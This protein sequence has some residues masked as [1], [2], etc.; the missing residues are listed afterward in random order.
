MTLH[1]Y[2][3]MHSEMTSN[4]ATPALI[5]THKIPTRLIWDFDFLW[6]TVSEFY[7]T[8]FSWQLMEDDLVI[9]VN[10]GTPVFLKEK[11]QEK[12]AILPYD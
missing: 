6:K 12:G 1:V 8:E 9:T 5:F 10:I 4:A 7:G 3:T 11:L 2:I